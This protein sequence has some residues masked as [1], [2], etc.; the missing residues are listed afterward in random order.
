[1]FIK[2]ERRFFS[3][4]ARYFLLYFLIY[5]IVSWFMRDE[6]EPFFSF[7]NFSHMVEMGCFMA[8]IFAVFDREGK[9]EI[10]A[11]PNFTVAHLKHV[12]SGVLLFLLISLPLCIILY[13]I[14]T[15]FRNEN[16][17]LLKEIVKLGVFALIAA[18][19]FTALLWFRAR[20]RRRNP[21]QDLGRFK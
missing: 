19:L 15:V 8:V 2:P 4:L 21:D 1:M 14:F 5:L 13:F 3:K 9:N 16:I 20:I 11:G 10:A 6:N 12:L 18:L 7:S 17:N